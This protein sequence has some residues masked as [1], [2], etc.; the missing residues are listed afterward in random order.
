[1]SS[2]SLL[3]LSLVPRGGRRRLPEVASAVATSVQCRRPPKYLSTASSSSS[4]SSYAEDKLA[5]KEIRRQRFEQRQARVEQLKTRRE[6]RPTEVK[7]TEFKTWYDKRR[8]F[9]EI[10]DRKARQE[11][12][13]WK[14]QVAAVVERL[15]LVLPVPDKWEQ[16]YLDLRKHLNQ[17]TWEYPAELARV[18]KKVD[19]SDELDGECVY[20]Y[21]LLCVLDICIRI[22]P[23][24]QRFCVLEHSS[25]CTRSGACGCGIPPRDRG[26]RHG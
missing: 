4:L 1:M 7:K 20:M 8:T 15:P 23:G 21:L 14:I 24:H 19:E 26:R 5:A 10:M 17:F 25:V 3:L 9:H 13:G 12:L 6:G 22:E 2:T 18:D 16:D 11:G